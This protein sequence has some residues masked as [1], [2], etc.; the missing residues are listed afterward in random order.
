LTTAAGLAA[1]DKDAP[2]SPLIWLILTSLLAAGLA[3]YWFS[4][5]AWSE[6]TLG[7]QATVT[8]DGKLLQFAWTTTR[9][10]GRRKSRLAYDHAHPG[11]VQTRF[12]HL[13]WY[14]GFAQQGQPIGREAVK[15]QELASNPAVQDRTGS[16]TDSI[17]R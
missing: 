9:V 11:I 12:G 1:P 5:Y 7:C 14:G 4:R 17:V 15:W 16:G 13:A 10:E 2:L 3:W 8:A 6:R